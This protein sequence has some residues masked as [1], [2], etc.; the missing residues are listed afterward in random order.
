MR[1][2]ITE[3]SFTTEENWLFKLSDGYSDYFILSE[4]FYKKKG[5]KNPIGKKEF[6]SWDVGFSVLCE[7]LEFEEQKVVV[8]IN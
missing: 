4:E 6:D 2:K 1:L 8:K 3:V 7:V 5:L